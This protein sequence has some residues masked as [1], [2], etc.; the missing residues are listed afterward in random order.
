[1]ELNPASGGASA[2]V[3]GRNPSAIRLIMTKSV[4]S[5]LIC[6]LFFKRLLSYFW[7][8]PQSGT[9]D[10]VIALIFKL[11]SGDIKFRFY[12]VFNASIL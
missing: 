8:I 2:W 7:V 12:F 4:N 1:M 11:V 6:G 10:D 5:T 9:I 3:W